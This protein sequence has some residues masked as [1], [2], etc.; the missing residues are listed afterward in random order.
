MLKKN[1]HLVQAEFFMRKLDF[2]TK[3]ISSKKRN[4][5]RIH[6]SLTPNQVSNGADVHLGHCI[7]H[8]L[9]SYNDLNREMYCCGT[10]QMTAI[11][12]ND[13]MFSRWKLSKAFLKSI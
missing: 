9:F 10:P 7:Q 12:H 4:G 1:F 3:S 8:D 5:G 6:F 2:K 13:G 11:F